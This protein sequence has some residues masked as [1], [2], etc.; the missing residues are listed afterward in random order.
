MTIPMNQ[1]PALTLFDFVKAVDQAKQAGETGKA[2]LGT[3]G[4][5]SFASSGI[6]GYVTRL[7][8]KFSDAVRGTTLAQQRHT[9]AQG[10]FNA[11]Q[12]IL[13]PDSPDSIQQGVIN[14]S[15]LSQ[16]VDQY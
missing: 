2:L 7:W 3:N 15:P 5:I 13:R 14:P 8:E 6:S 11:F 4:E 12:K 10:A 1:R 9:Q 16:A